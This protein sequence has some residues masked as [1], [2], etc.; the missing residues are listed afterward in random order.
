[1]KKYRVLRNCS[2]FKGR[3]WN[4]GAEVEFEDDETP[5]HHFQLLSDVRTTAPSV[6][7]KLDP[8]KPIPTEIGKPIIARTGMA[9]G[10]EP[11]IPQMP[12]TA[13]MAAKR[14]RPKKE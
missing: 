4:E 7:V 1:M 9:A 14:G 8:M 2:G 13:S 5:P 6:T 12:L 11:M 10:L 3:R